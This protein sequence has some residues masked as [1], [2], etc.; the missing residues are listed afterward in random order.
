M[1][2]HTESALISVSLSHRTAPVALREQLAIP[3]DQ[4]ADELRALV[5]GPGEGHA[6]REAMVV[7]TCNRVEVYVVAEDDAE[8]RLRAWLRQRRGA[9]AEIEPHLT[10]R[11]G[12]DAVR[13]LFRVAS[14]LD[15]LVVG[16]PQILGQVK[17]AVRAAADADALGTVLHRLTQRALWV[18]K[19]VRTRT[20]IGR[21]HVGVGNAG[22]A[23]AQQIFSSLRGRRAMLL[24]AGEMGRQVA[25]AMVGAGLSELVVANR[26]FATAV[27]LAEPHGGTPIA[28]ERV[29]EYLAHVDIVIAA[30][31]AAQ[32]IISVDQVRAAL[33]ARRWR[34]IFLVDL[35]VPRNIAPEVHALE[36]AF[37][38]N[39][40]DL[41]QVVERGAAA[42]AAASADAE[43]ICE[44]E[45]ARFEERLA[46]LEA[47]DA[48]GAVVRRAESLRQVELG[49]SARWLAGLD[50]AQRDGVDALTRALVKK[51]LHGP[52]RA[53]REAAAEGDVERLRA[54]AELYGVTGVVGAE[55]AS[56]VDGS[57][58]GLEDPPHPTLIV[59]GR[60][61]GG[62]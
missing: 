18:A 30:T 13:H 7:S 40:D 41:T 42:R 16:E 2:T 32:P 50:T 14:S 34:P 52:L 46:L 37:V 53:M 49:R 26:T 10:W 21:F 11:R 62:R 25:A 17:D 33:R 35:A 57:A 60:A 8:E 31:G 47:N 38:F 22:V 45:A 28:F 20:D 27:A 29:P 6:A 12:G 39:V 36:Q 55:E 59:G 54:V 19:Q 3:R 23:L 51:L 44:E 24:G 43:R 58:S 56:P 48:L 9:S 5:A 4:L 61:G 1:P 15:S